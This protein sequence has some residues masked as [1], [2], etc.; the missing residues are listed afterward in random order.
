VPDNDNIHLKD[1]RNVPREHVL[2]VNAGSPGFLVIN[3]PFYPGWHAYIDNR[4]VPL[5]HV[6]ELFQGI[7]LPVGSYTVTVVYAPRLFSVGL[8]LSLAA[9]VLVIG[10]LVMK[11]FISRN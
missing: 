6:N 5:D 10:M 9:S 3:E 7:S 2:R 11:L 4:Q 1:I 8:I